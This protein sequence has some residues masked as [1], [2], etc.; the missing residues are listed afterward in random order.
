HHLD[1]NAMYKNHF[2]EDA[3]LTRPPQADADN[4]VAAPVN[5]D[6]DAAALACTSN[7]PKVAKEETRLP[8]P[9]GRP[10]QV[11]LDV[12][13]TLGQWDWKHAALIAT[14]FM[15]PVAPSMYDEID[16]DNTFGDEPPADAAFSCKTVPERS[17][18]GRCCAVS[19]RWLQRTGPGT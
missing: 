12:C 13:D 15:V 19:E 5:A 10:T 4:A 2:F 11:T 1:I 14:R 7:P 18:L 17:L 6:R 3:A 8:S 16:I 9:G